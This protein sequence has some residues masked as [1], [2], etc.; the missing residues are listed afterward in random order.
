[1]K[2]VWHIYYA[3]KGTSGAYIDALLKASGIAG[4]NAAA[5]VS[6]NYLFRHG[7]VYK[8][9]FPVTDFTEE[10][11][12][13]IKLLRGMELCFSYMYIGISAAIARSIVV[14]HL[15][16]DFHITY[17]FFKFCKIAGLTVRI[18]CH[19]VNSHYLGMNNNRAR[20]LVQA[21]E[22]LVHNEAAV[23]MLCDNLGKSVKNKVKTYPFPYSAFDEIV[24]RQKIDSARDRLRDNVGS[25]YYL[26]LGVVRR[27]KGIETL[28][29]AWPQFN[30][31]KRD[32][33]VIA[34][35]WTDPD[36]KYRKMA[37]DDETIAVIDRYLDDE[38]FVHLIEGAKF[39]VL[40]Y[41]EYAHSAI[42]VSCGHHGG[43]VIVSDIELFKQYL[44]NYSC[45]FRRGD[46]HAL[47]RILE[48]ASDLTE[49]EIANCRQEL[50][51]AI[52]SQSKH[53][54]EDLREAYRSGN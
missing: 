7:R 42:I 20:I 36:E 8:C 48:S 40:P 21:D 41:L 14:I 50:K 25:N 29:E 31:G 9:F 38:E 10:R 27:S 47:A 45:T 46:S 43:A 32:R 13:F 17:L 5:F 52:L 23:R 33:L 49:E 6:A 22:L 4:I 15:I 19:D 39:V 1:M 12:I 18:T 11:N 51:Q 44:P 26:F 35:K 3:T 34:G 24:S 2:P 16:D 30:L 28:I 54:V 53:L 37:D